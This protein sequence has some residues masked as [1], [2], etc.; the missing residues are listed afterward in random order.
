MAI[1]VSGEGNREKKIDKLLENANFTKVVHKLHK[2]DS[3]YVHNSWKSTVFGNDQIPKLISW[4][5]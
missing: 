3:I 2:Q 4:P 5:Q 1:E